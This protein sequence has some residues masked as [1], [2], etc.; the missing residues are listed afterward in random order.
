LTSLDGGED[1]RGHERTHE[2]ELEREPRVLL[3]LAEPEFR[4]AVL[5]LLT[6][7]GIPV[8]GEVT[9]G[10]GAIT[11]AMAPPPEDPDVVVVAS[12]LAGL[13]PVW[14][15]VRQI[16][17]ATPAVQVIAL[18]DDPDGEAAARCRQGG[19]WSVL[20]RA[21]SAAALLDSLRAAVT[22]PTLTGPRAG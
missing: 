8:L 22:I 10:S 14:D 5:Q 12:R 2:R 7:D 1:Q 21:G 6:E 9:S 15:V 17:D 18:L 3:A 16:R 11:A 19:A 13:L 20:D 4:R